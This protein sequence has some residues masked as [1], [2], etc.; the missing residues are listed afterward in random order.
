MPMEIPDA[1]T[2]YVV[3]PERVINHKWEKNADK[4]SRNVKL[5]SIDELNALLPEKREQNFAVTAFEEGMVLVFDK[6]T[7]KYYS[8]DK[9][10][11]ELPLNKDRAIDHIAGLLGARKITRSICKNQ[12]SKRELSVN[13]E[14]QIKLFEADGSYKHAH[15][16]KRA[17]K[18][19]GERIFPGQYSEQGFNMALEYARKCGLY[20]DAVVKS[21]LDSRNPKHPNRL[22]R[23]KY[24]VSMT[25]EVEDLSEYAFSVKYLAFGLSAKVEEAVSTSE[26]IE[27]SLEI[28]YGE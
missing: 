13:G 7:N 26:T 16:E 3:S 4:L 12:T 10:K 28:E 27:V 8:I 22:L 25:S 24:E 18:Y 11:D 20:E 9:A 14:V 6:I 19:I 15:L 21:M 17:R 1:L 2:L 23:E 5:I